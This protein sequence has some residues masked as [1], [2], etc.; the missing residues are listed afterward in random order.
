MTEQATED[1]DDIASVIRESMEQ[2]SETDDTAAPEPEASPTAA[3]EPEA[4]Q[5]TAA[6]SEPAAAEEGKWKEDRAPSSWTPKARERWESI[7]PELRR[8]IVRREEAA[9][10]GVRQ[11]QEKFQPYENFYK[12]MS[13]VVDEA[14]SLGVAPE[15]HIMNAV[16][17]ERALRAPDVPSRFQAL[18][19]MADQ[20]G[21]PL[22][23]VV[24]ASVGEEVLKGKGQAAQGGVPAEVA[25]EL[26]EI[27]HWRDSMERDQVL[28]EVSSFSAGK[29]F[30]EDVRFTM[31]NLI[32]SGAAEN[33]DQAYEQAIWAVPAVREVLIAR[34]AA[35][36]T[37]TG[38]RQRQQAAASVGR[39]AGT[40][41]V[42]VPASDED[43]DDD[44][45]SIVRTQMARSN[46]GRV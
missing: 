29:E 2:V 12:F 24:N 15:Q 4:A 34:T 37:S 8:E 30:F 44:I 26:E 3:A 40:S 42:H 25:R 16:M 35:G 39:V 22:R 43:G 38:V 41:G 33:L 1:K 9:V 32:R 10:S 21:I 31:G 27:R 20:Y 5:P 13:P 17:M 6:A 23:E 19:R 46:T 36:S 45:A 28:G 18:L 11:I 7:D 14:R